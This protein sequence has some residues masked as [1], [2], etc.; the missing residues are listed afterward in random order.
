METLREF[1]FIVGKMIFDEPHLGLLKGQHVFIRTED[2][3]PETVQ[4]RYE[5]INKWCQE[6]WVTIFIRDEFISIKLHQINY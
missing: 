1:H 2:N 6:S 5:C 4:I 3:D